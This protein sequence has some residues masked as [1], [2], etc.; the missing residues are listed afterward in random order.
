MRRG[1]HSSIRW[2]GQRSEGGA[3][4]KTFRFCQAARYI[5]G[6]SKNESIRVLDRL[7]EPVSRCL[8]LEGARALADLEADPAAQARMAELA[9]K[10]NEGTLTTEERSEYE[11]C[12]HAGNLIAI[13]QAQ[14]RLRL[15]PASTH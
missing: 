12:V 11:A 13:L 8:N 10:C 7:L 3:H 1:V 5:A 9:E 14:A 4:G 2:N 15:K 6:M